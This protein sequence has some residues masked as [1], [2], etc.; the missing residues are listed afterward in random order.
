M[1]EAHAQVVTS[2]EA[3]AEYTCGTAVF[4]L[5]RDRPLA[6]LS[7][8]PAALDALQGVPEFVRAFGTEHCERAT[9]QFLYEYF[10][11]TERLE[12]DDAAF[13][14]TFEAFVDEL[15]D[16]NWTYVAFANLR[17]FESDDALID[18][19]DRISIR[20]RS[21]EEIEERLGW[22]EW[23]FDH[24]ARDWTEGHAASGHVVWIESATEKKPDTAVLSD[25]ATGPGRA[26]DLLLALWL[27]PPG[28]PSI[29]AI[30]TDRAAR[31]DL[32]GRGLA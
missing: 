21:Y 12:F 27:F 22:T 8:L 32:T 20:H 11:R 31:F 18:F 16:P 14:A 1:A 28:D 19:G 13:D 30:F 4:N 3:L 5:E 7:A 9:L 24:L 15:D 26:L 6:D 17:N 29:G 25:S 10:T 23:H 2:A